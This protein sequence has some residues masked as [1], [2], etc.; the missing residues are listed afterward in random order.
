M[1]DLADELAREHGLPFVD[2]VRAAVT[3]AESLVRLGLKTSRLG[4]YSVPR[5]K[6]YSGLLAGFRP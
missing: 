1:V 4:A 6:P 3:L 2:G 5:Q